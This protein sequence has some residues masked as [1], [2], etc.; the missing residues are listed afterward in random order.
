MIVLKQ[1][2]LNNFTTVNNCTPILSLHGVEN[3][4]H[5]CTTQKS[6]HWMFLSSCISN[7]RKFY[8]I[9]TVL[10][11]K[12]DVSKTQSA[13]FKDFESL[14][15]IWYTFRPESTDVVVPDVL[16]APWKRRLQDCICGLRSKEIAS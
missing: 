13:N 15:R 10:Q 4:G 6:P 7:T 16:G 1:W 5:I 9:L 12:T 8:Q 14:Q 11:C 3:Y 2:I